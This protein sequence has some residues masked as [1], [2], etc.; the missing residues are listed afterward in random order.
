MMTPPSRCS[1]VR[2]SLSGK[3]QKSGRRL[4]RP[5][6]SI[7]RAR[8]TAD[9]APAPGVSTFEHPHARLSGCMERGA[10]LRLAG[11]AFM[12]DLFVPPRHSTKGRLPASW[13]TEDRARRAGCYKGARRG[14]PA[15][16]VWRLAPRL[17]HIVTQDL[18]CAESRPGTW[19]AP[20]HSLPTTAPLA[21]ADR[22]THHLHSL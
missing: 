11:Q 7:A 8:S 10:S 4:S 3:H 2:P 19:L 15:R 13:R 1:A 12:P 17:L 6:R 22:T 5:G 21:A 14:M 9:R 20:R 18:G 16:Q